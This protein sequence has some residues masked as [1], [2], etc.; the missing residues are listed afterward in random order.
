MVPPLI[1]ARV[2]GMFPGYASP[3]DARVRYDT[4][5]GPDGAQ[6]P[7]HLSSK[8]R[9]M[10]GMISVTSDGGNRVLSGRRCK[11]ASSPKAASGA[12]C[13]RANQPFVE[14]IDRRTHDPL[15]AVFALRGNG[16]DGLLGSAG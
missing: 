15:G 14:R 4:Q 16:P 9:N 8:I 10:R 3:P 6:P 2:S 12:V 7:G 1:R 11:F 13:V 5:G